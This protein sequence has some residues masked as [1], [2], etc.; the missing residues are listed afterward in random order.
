MLFVVA[1]LALVVGVLF[2]ESA[3]ATA[4]AGSVVSP[5]G[6]DAPDDPH[7]NT[8]KLADMT[9]VYDASSQHV[10]TTYADGTTV[11]I[12]RDATGRIAARTVGPAGADPAK[13]TKYLY[14]G[15]GDAAWGQIAG[16]TVA[17]SATLP[18]GLSRTAVGAT[19]TWSFPDLLGHGL[20]TRTGT[21]TGAMLMWDPF[22]QPVDPATFA[23]GT[24]ATDDAAQVSGDT[25]WHQ[26]ALK[27]AESAGSTLVIEMGARLYVPALGRFLQVD[28]VEGGVDNAYNYPTDPVNAND[29]T[30]LQ[31]LRESIVDNGL[32]VAGVVGLFALV[33]GVCAIVGAVGAAVSVGMG[34]YRVSTGRPEGVVDI[35]SGATGGVLGAAARAAKSAAATARTLTARK[36]T[37]KFNTRTGWQGFNNA[38]SKADDAAFWFGAAETVRGAASAISSTWVTKSITLANRRAAGGRTIAY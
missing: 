10:G 35:L 15:P 2:A 26:S 6:P 38:A 8:T 7:G 30:G 21:T 34:V 1:V 13:T 12:A 27:P 28:S 20:I 16:S 33:C 11:S 23:L 24:P 25:L 37:R 19:V 22:G 36:V 32:L 17:T 29:L 4:V 14:A 9:F 3:S 5:E 31:A 18:G